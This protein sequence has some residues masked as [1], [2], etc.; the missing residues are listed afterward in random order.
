[1]TSSECLMIV[2]LAVICGTTIIG[3]IVNR[4]Q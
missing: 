4:K 3:A 2:C 1:M